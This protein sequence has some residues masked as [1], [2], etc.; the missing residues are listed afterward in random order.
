MRKV[1]F[2][3]RT[4][5]GKWSVGMIVAGLLFF[6][7]ANIIAG[8]QGPRADQTI[9]D[10]PLLSV[11]MILA[12]L[13]VISS[14]FTGVIGMIWRRERAVLVFISSLIGFLLLVFLIGEFLVP[15]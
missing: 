6:T 4:Y 5:L 11:P 1:H 9:F 10:N 14:F 8:L 13:S 15:H 7:F 3:P 12:G 2:V